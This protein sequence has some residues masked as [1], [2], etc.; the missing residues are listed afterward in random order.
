ML[1]ST[2]NNE[3]I[4]KLN[5]KFLEILRDRG[6]V[7]SYLLPPLSKNT[8]LEKTNQYKLG[9][10]PSSNGVNDLLL[11]KTIPLTLYN[12]LLRFRHTDKKIKMDGD[13]LKKI[14]NKNYN[15]NL[16]ILLAEN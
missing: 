10:Y 4:E 9:K 1:T 3:A 12:N 5:D 6:I 2:E 7:A 8:N 15:I 14:T 16:A 11:N 13:L